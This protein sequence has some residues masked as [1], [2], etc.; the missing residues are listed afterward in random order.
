MRRYK[1]LCQEHLPDKGSFTFTRAGRCRPG[2]PP[3]LHRARL[4]TSRPRRQMRYFR[5]LAQARA[6]AWAHPGPYGARPGPKLSIAFIRQPTDQPDSM[7][8]STHACALH[9]LYMYTGTGSSHSQPYR[10]HGRALMQRLRCTQ[11]PTASRECR[12]KIMMGSMSL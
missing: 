3:P 5:L 9:S 10:Y 8:V 7:A 2:A 1:S 4:P 11:R 6:A 12:L